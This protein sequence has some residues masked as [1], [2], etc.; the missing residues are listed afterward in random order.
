MPNLQ[1]ILSDAGA[2]RDDVRRNAEAQLAQASAANFPEYCKA[3]ASELCNENC[4]I[5]GIRQ[6][7][8]LVLKNA[9]SST[10]PKTDA[11]LRDK[12]VNMMQG[13]DKEMIKRSVL[14][15]VLVQQT[16]A[17]EARRTACQVAAKIARL[18]VPLNTWPEFFS[19]ILMTV[20]SPAPTT[21]E[22]RIG[23][24]C[25]LGYFTED[26]QGLCEEW[27][28]DLMSDENKGLVL[29]S[30]S[31]G[32]TDPNLDVKLAAF[33]GFYHGILF[34]ERF[35]ALDSDRHQLFVLIGEA[36][37]C[38]RIDVAKAAWEVLFQMADGYYLYLDEIL[39]DIMKLTYERCQAPAVAQYED[40]A[41]SAIEFWSTIC[42]EEILIGQ[43]NRP[44]RLKNYVAK[45]KDHLL[46]ILYEATTF[47]DDEETAEDSDWCVAVAAGACVGLCAQV[48]KDDILPSALS[49]IE[50]NFGSP[51]WN[52]REA[53]VL[54][55]GS[56]L[57]GPSNDKFAPKLRASFPMLCQT[58]NDPSVVVR[59]TCAWAIGSIAKNH[60][61][62]I[63]PFLGPVNGE[64]GLVQ[65]LLRKLDD[66][67]R[68]AKNACFA[69]YEIFARSE[70]VKNI[71]TYSISSNFR[72]LSA[73]LIQVA[74]RPDGSE[75][76]LRQA[77]FNTLYMLISQADVCEDVDQLLRQFVTWMDQTTKLAY[78][79]E[80]GQLQGPMIG[81][82]T[83]IIDL[84]S[85]A[86]LRAESKKLMDSFMDVLYQGTQISANNMIQRWSPATEEVL[87]ATSMLCCQL[88]TGFDPYVEVIAPTLRSALVARDIDSQVT[89]VA[90]E[91]LGGIA[92]AC[93][94]KFKS[95]V[96]E[97]VE[98]F[99]IV[100]KDRSAGMDLKPKI[101]TVLCDIALVC[102][103]EFFPHIKSFLE[104]LR[105]AA[106]TRADQGP[107][108]DETW[109][110]YIINLRD[111]SLCG[112]S[113]SICCIRDCAQN[114]WDQA[115]AVNGVQLFTPEI[116]RILEF[117]TKVFNDK[118]SSPGNIRNA[119]RLLQDLIPMFKTNPVQALKNSVLYNI[120]KTHGQLTTDAIIKQELA[121]LEEVI[122]KTNTPPPLL[123]SYTRHQ[124]CFR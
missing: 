85:D 21:P 79:E 10:D 20:N 3:L 81:C 4:T 23:A 53:A 61:N 80:L 67:P 40:I 87:L 95:Y 56:I 119:I 28:R 77:A 120:L 68:V 115:Q 105:L 52:R 11:A 31:R 32:M 36:L 2:A 17:E 50:A 106:T 91:L 107:A 104:F 88:G 116:N 100:L 39:N 124:C 38:D 74:K 89:G 97:F 13:P 47:R 41:L 66:Q 123:P 18:E 63:A 29:S 114:G 60:L 24:Y 35:V 14:E 72:Q 1:D 99:I 110:Q 101:I 64:G 94:N 75:N 96:S 7:A 69:L 5:P 83:A 109:L 57:E 112:Y 30:L 92:T 102:P 8:G 22:S 122:T 6:R 42:D 82:I 15:L 25:L 51:Q 90:V 26:V 9:I 117:V 12:W 59:D 76:Q 103:H 58:L 19:A 45:Y 46:P 48:L 98:L 34:A 86:L 111:A 73:E 118:F 33:K 54:I 43:E 78:T 113:A 62:V 93:P 49:F 16:K 44:E 84:S 71:S 65:L 108:D 70:S 37:N 121:R 55:Y 27:G